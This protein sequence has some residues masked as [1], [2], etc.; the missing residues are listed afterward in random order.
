MPRRLGDSKSSEASSVAYSD[1]FAED[2]QGMLPAHKKRV[3]DR[4][5]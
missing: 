2:S 5:Q 4:A 1:D 3:S